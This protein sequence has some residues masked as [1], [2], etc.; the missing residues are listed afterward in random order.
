MTIETMHTPETKYRARVEDREGD[1]WAVI[2][3]LAFL[4][5]HC[6]E[7]N[8]KIIWIHPLANTRR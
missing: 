1:R 4:D 8:L 2:G 7:Q 3:S 5:R 6:A